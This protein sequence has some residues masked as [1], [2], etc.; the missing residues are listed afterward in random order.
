MLKHGDYPGNE[1]EWLCK[2]HG[3]DAE[4]AHTV[5]VDFNGFEDS[6]ELDEET[7]A[8]SGV[9]TGIQWLLVVSPLFMWKVQRL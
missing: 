8:A 9:W 7:M 5:F 3:G 1:P 6:S 4:A 2:L